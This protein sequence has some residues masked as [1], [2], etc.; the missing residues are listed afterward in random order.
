MIRLG[1]NERQMTLPCENNITIRSTWKSLADQSTAY[2]S[3]STGR[4]ALTLSRTRR[5]TTT[6]PS[7]EIP[8]R[9][10]CMWSTLI[11][12]FPNSFTPI[13]SGRRSR[14]RPDLLRL[15]GS[16]S[17]AVLRKRWRRGARILG[18]GL[19]FPGLSDFEILFH[20][21]RRRTKCF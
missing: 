6:K 20:I 17:L 12:N 10:M 19:E 11:P 18:T 1:E 16:A 8:K 2:S 7:S 9:A 15:C 14:L 21:H 5:A 4:W 13:T 3:R